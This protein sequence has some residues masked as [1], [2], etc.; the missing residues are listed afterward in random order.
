MGPCFLAAGRPLKVLPTRFHFSA[1]GRRA[2]IKGFT[3]AI[4]FFWPPGSQILRVDLNVNS[5]REGHHF[6]YTLSLSQT[7]R[8]CNKKNLY[9]GACHFEKIGKNQEDIMEGFSGF[10][11]D[12]TQR[13][14]ARF[15][16][17][18]T[19]EIQRIMAGFSLDLTQEIRSLP[20]K[21]FDSKTKI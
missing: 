19:Q 10:F 13:I 1:A 4:P 5:I 9:R 17:D 8:F 15:S 3:N 14:M 12:M 21:R 6:L 18:L 7:F 16:L 2:P 20:K 11:N